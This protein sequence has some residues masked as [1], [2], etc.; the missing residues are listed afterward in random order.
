[1]KE[2]TDSQKKFEE[3]IFAIRDLRKKTRVEDLSSEV[4]NLFSDNDFISEDARKVFDF[5][6]R[7]LLDILKI[8][9]LKSSRLKTF[10]KKSF[11]LHL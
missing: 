9:I 1:M 10:W 7:K 4:L 6:K 2:L 8:A 5:Y 11:P 3:N